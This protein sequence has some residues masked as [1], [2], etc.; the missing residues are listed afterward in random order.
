MLK[1]YHNVK[2]LAQHLL[3]N[4]LALAFFVKRLEQ[5]PPSVTL[6]TSEGV[7]AMRMHSFELCEL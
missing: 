1:A 4:E 7:E 3:V 2:L 5:I 6:G